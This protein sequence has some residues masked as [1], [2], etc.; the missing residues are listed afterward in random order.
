MLAI[1]IVVTAVAGGSIAIAASRHTPECRGSVTYGIGF[2]RCGAPSPTS[3]TKPGRPGYAQYAYDECQV[4]TTT[5]RRNEH[6]ATLCL[7]AGSTATT[8]VSP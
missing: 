8:P 3:S 7:R 2:S 4:V 5:L 6:V 1:A